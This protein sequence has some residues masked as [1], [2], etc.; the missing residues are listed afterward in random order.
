[1]GE[2]VNPGLD[3]LEKRKNAYKSKGV[4]YYQ[5]WLVLMTDGAPNGD[6]NELHRA[7]SRT[8]EMVNQK[9]LSVF[10][11]GIGRDADIEMLASFSPKRSL[12][13]LKDLK[14][15]EFFEWGSAKAYPELLSLF[16]GKAFL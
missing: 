9:K 7:I 16:R 1:M 12:L 3:L 8:A 14:F 2:A 15:R 6:Y 11:I 5:P 10:P 4:D 13:K